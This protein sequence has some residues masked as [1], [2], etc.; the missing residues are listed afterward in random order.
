VEIGMM[1]AGNGRVVLNELNH[2]GAFITGKINITKKIRE[3]G[4]K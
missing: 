3:G 2:G 4:Y 1:A